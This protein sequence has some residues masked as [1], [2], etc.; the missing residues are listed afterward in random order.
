MPKVK[1]STLSDTPNRINHGIVC[2]IYAQFDC[3]TTM[4]SSGM[5]TGRTPSCPAA[6]ISCGVGP[7]SGGALREAPHPPQTSASS[8]LSLPHVGHLISPTERTVAPHDLQDV[9]SSL[10]VAPQ[11]PQFCAA[12]MILFPWSFQVQSQFGQTCLFGNIA[13]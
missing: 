1:K 8:R 12:V 3:R 13:W 7:V 6:S 11:F 9:A 2:N 5:A 4:A 10:G